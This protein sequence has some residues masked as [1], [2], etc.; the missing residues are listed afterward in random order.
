MK[1]FA[2]ILSLLSM[3]GCVF[4]TSGL[5]SDPSAC[6]GTAPAAL[7]QDGVCEGSLQ[8]C[9]LGLWAEPDYTL[10]EGHEA[11][12]TSC[13]DLDNDCD[14][15]VDAGDCG[16]HGA[17]DDGSGAPACVCESGWQPDLAAESFLCADIDECETL[18]CDENA[19]CA[20]TPGAFTCTCNPGFDGDGFV[21]TPIDPCSPSPCS[22][23]AACTEVD[24]QAVCTCE[25]GFTGD[26]LTC[27]PKSCFHLLQRYPSTPSGD[28][29]IDTGVGGPI[30]VTCDMD[31]D[32]RLG[33]TLIRFDDP[34]LAADQDAYREVCAAV[35][36]EVVVPRTRAHARSI[37]AF[38]GG[39]L[40]NLVNVFP[41]T[42]GAVGLEN[43]EGRCEGAPCSFY[44]SNSR[45][46]Q[47]GTSEPSGDNTT[48]YSLYLR[49][50]D[51]S[52]WGGWNDQTNF[53]DAA[54]RGWV[55]CSTNDTPEPR[56]EDCLD[57]AVHDTVWN[58]GILGITGDYAVTIDGTPMTV[59]CD[60][61]TDGGGWTL[62]M[63]YLHRRN[64]NPALAV[65]TDR[66]PLLR[67]DT[68]GADESAS[69]ESWGHAGNAM[70]SRLP[71][72]EVRF[73]GRTS[74]HARVINFTTA[75]KNCIDY[76]A[77][78]IGD[79]R[80]AGLNVHQVAGHSANLPIKVNNS[81]VDQGDLAMTRFPF[82]QTSTAHFGVRGGTNRWEV[83]DFQNN[84]ARDTIHRL[85]VRNRPIGVTCKTIL[86]ANPQAPSGV[87][88]LDPDGP[89]GG[90]DPYLTWCDMTT[91]GGGW[92]LVAIYGKGF[93]RPTRFSGSAYPRPG[94]GF[95]HSESPLPTLTMD[96]LAPAAN[97]GNILNFSIPAA[98]LFDHSGGEVLAWVGGVTDSYIVATL[99]MTCN[100]FDATVMCDDRTY[101]P[102]T[103]FDAQGQ[104]V[105]ED[106]YACTTSH[107]AA[108]YTADTYDEFGL[109]LLD[110]PGSHVTYHCATT[111]TPTGHEGYGRMFTSFNASNGNFWNAG[112]H[113]Y[114]H[115]TG[116]LDQP[117][118]L[119]IR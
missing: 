35:G 37:V 25:D 107:K 75:D 48:A 32:G 66:L 79:C 77:T 51:G 57:Y 83:D 113:S 34:A 94:A 39:A 14:G 44:L 19:D 64:T 3:I 86:L 87:Y 108:P 13:D 93:P 31:T 42:D 63:N 52:D 38:N 82:Y 60:Q 103:I 2:I 30:T 99:P 29:L 110:G 7:L 102:F 73:F 78:G 89:A 91:A 49:N 21:C 10:L 11:A 95:Y 45:I 68:L 46:S 58:K 69:A 43:W 80:N 98:P 22:P 74:G 16:E 4:D 54:F 12:E 119:F 28:Y 67:S 117:G 118:A 106:G 100:Y 114:W 27:R 26:G 101:G 50:A 36:M 92:T 6:D 55:V 71:V 72:T 23:D 56:R 105:T 76:L 70:F 24:G 84:D 41:K 81:Y 88:I 5:S 112:V 15:I 20:N 90:Q 8:V 109:H 18:P 47:T 96:V 33:Y 61:V 17:C 85:W 53:V 104:K 62:V 115:P 59:T 116:V 111:A 40:P 9:V 1:F 97:N 65:L